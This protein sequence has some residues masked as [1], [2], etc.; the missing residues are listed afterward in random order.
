LA[1][2]LGAFTSASP[3]STTSPSTSQTQDSRARDF[4]G[5]SSATVTMT[6]TV[7]PIFTGARK[8]SVCEM[9]T[10]PGPGKR[11]PSTAEIRLA[12]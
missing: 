12:V 1:W 7:S 6:V 8:L 9:Y 11:V 3:S 5:I 4:S 2:A 10:A